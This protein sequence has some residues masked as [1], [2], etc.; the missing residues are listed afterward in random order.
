MIR[1][2][3]AFAD[4]GPSQPAPFGIRRGDGLDEGSTLLDPRYV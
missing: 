3:T 1:S 4:P 2:G